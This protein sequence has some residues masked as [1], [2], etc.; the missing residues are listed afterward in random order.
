M[1]MSPYISQ[2]LLNTWFPSAEYGVQ[3]VGGVVRGVTCEGDGPGSL[4]L[5]LSMPISKFF[6]TP[7]LFYARDVIWQLPLNIYLFRAGFL[8]TTAELF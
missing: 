8:S 4:R 1:G 3:I 7:I 2:S 6:N 5:D